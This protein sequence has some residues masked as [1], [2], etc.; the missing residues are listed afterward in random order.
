MLGRTPVRNLARTLGIPL[1][2][3]LPSEL[4]T[5]VRAGIGLQ[6]V[7]AAQDPG[8][9]LLRN[10]GGATAR[11]LVER[12]VLRVESIADADH[13]FTDSTRRQQLVSVLERAL[14]D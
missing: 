11:K 7:F 12:G 4:N 3:D 5:V 2:D 14:C 10:Q 6:F 1:S 8:V 9:E 13:T